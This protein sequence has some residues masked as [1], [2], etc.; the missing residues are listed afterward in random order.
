MTNFVK[1]TR[2]AAAFV[3][4]MASAGPALAEETATEPM[5]AVQKIA[6]VVLAVDDLDAS[7]AFYAS[8]LHMSVIRNTSTEAYKEAILATGDVEGTKIVLY[9]SLIET[10][11][12]GPSSR[13]VFYTG[14]A[15]A[16]VAAFREQGLEVVREATPVAEGSP[17]RIGI[18]KDPDGH[19][20]E[21]IQ[22]GS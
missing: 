6:A 11:A 20:L 8:T 7:V 13:V 15:A 16:F 5:P 1:K 2:A 9:E 14:D 21:F 22:R 17:V 19:T 4:I 12:P 10:D 18:V 3:A